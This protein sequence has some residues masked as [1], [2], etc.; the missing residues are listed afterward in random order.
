MCLQDGPSCTAKKRLAGRLSGRQDGRLCDP[1]HTTDALHNFPRLP[2]HPSSIPVLLD[3]HLTLPTG[4]RV[5]LRH[6]Q[7]RDRAGLLALLERVGLG[8][9]ELDLQR[10]VRFDPRHRAV[11]CATAWTGL[12]ETVVGLGAI[13]YGAAAP[14][15]VIADETLAPGLGATLEGVL[16]GA[17]AVRRAA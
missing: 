8:A 17:D 11:V 3:T 12:G 7:S 4:V 15:L 5:R 14:D 1:T 16:T 9:E 10:A 6:P 13:S 2:R